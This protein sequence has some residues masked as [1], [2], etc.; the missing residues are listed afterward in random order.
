M[1]ELIQ[2]VDEDALGAAVSEAVAAGRTLAIEGAGTKAGYGRPVLA[3]RRLSLARL[4]G[5]TYYEPG[6]LVLEAWA[7]T[8]LSEIEAALA[9]NGQQL[10]FEPPDLGPLYG[11]PPDLGTIGGVIACNLSG[12]RRPYAGAA[13]DHVLGI[14]AVSGRG[15]VFASGGR[16]VK[17]VTGYDMSKL[18]AGSF[19]T[20]AVLSRVIVKV[21]P[22]AE[23]VR[24]ALFVGSDANRAREILAKAGGAAWEVT[25]AA[26]VP[27]QE[28]GRSQV[29]YIAGS[30][31]AVALRLEGS[32]AGVTARARAVREALGMGGPT[33]EL[34]TS[35][36]LLF[37][38]EV[39]G[40][41]LL[42]ARNE[43]GEMIWRISCP[44]ARGLAAADRIID[45]LGGEAVFDWGGGMV[46][47]ALPDPGSVEAAH[48]QAD[49]LR[50]MA[51]EHEGYATLIRAPG[52][53]REDVP[54][55]HPEEA[56]VAALSR[57]VKEN[58]DPLGVLNPGRVVQG[59]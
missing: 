31:G 47:L 36:S 24:T 29:P 58:F 38:A 1:A 2:P 54:V 14:R 48:G 33:E 51:E 56:G 8:P 57:R 35:L 22:R 55:F 37:W 40:G 32:R 59:L 11:G 41:A 42:P 46:W 53:F 30:G 44:P 19:G 28:A 45:A 13:R 27:A 10:A 52:N 6:E 23:V 50:A 49:R 17:N 9:E 4:S 25:G 43:D 21:L 34:H 39:A 15:E 5:I 12:S 20:L 26:F 18:M 3:D 16:V 7:G